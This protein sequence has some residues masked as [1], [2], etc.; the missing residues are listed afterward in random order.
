MI[1]PT[2]LNPSHLGSDYNSIIP[3]QIHTAVQTLQKGIEDLKQGNY[4]SIEFI[5]EGLCGLARVIS[6]ENNVNWQQNQWSKDPRY[7]LLAH[8]INLIPGEGGMQLFSQMPASQFEQA[9]QSKDIEH[10]ITNDPTTLS[11][12]GSLATSIEQSPNVGII[13]QGDTFNNQYI[14]TMLRTVS[15]IL[16]SQYSTNTSGILQHLTESS[17]MHSV[18]Q[19]IFTEANTPPQTGS[20]YNILQ[21]YFSGEASLQDAATAWD[22]VM[23]EF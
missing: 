10:M 15:D 20:P 2:N 18:L 3:A 23:Q 7:G 12:I 8:I 11:I 1:D 4:P 14:H 16:Y 6:N 19:E 13:S 22:T 21:Q 9:Q 17:T 5:R